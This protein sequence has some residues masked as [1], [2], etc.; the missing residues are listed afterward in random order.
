L[1][2]QRLNYWRWAGLEEATDPIVKVANYRTKMANMAT[3][4]ATKIIKIPRKSPKAG[5]T[6]KLSPP[7]SAIGPPTD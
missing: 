5:K 4:T 7:G 1:P 3:K 2:H 6:A